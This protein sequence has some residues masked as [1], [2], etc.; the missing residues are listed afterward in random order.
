M[1]FQLNLYGH[2]CMVHRYKYT[3]NIYI[4]MYIYCK[5]SSTHLLYYI[6]IWISYMA[7][8]QTLGDEGTTKQ[9]MFSCLIFCLKGTSWLVAAS[10]L[11]DKLYTT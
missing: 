6:D 3:N 5:I 10:I 2:K 9:T 8:T 11:G 4:Y 7:I 1:L